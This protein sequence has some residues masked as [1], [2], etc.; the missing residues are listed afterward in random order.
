MRGGISRFSVERFS[1]HG[2]QKHLRV[3]LLISKK[4]GNSEIFLF[5]IGRFHDFP[6]KIFSLTV[7]KNFVG[8]FFV[9]QKTSSMESIMDKRKGIT[10]F[11]LKFFVSKCRKSSWASLSMFQK[12]WGVE[13]FLCIL[14][15]ITFFP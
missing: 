4:I 7:L 6:S 12:F 10:D 9:S 1:S 2:A 15:G 11:R 13:K 3:T 5:I 14:G 8:N